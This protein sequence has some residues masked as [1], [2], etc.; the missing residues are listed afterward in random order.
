MAAEPSEITFVVPGQ[1][2]PT[3]QASTALSGTVKAAVRVGARRGAGETVRMSARPG[4][5]VVLLHIANGPTLCLHPENA[6]ELVQA[7]VGGTPPTGRSQAQV[8]GEVVVPAQLGWRGLEAAP[9]TRGKLLDWAGGVVLDGIEVVTGLLKDKL[10]D[11]A[12]AAVT[13]KLDGQVDAGVY[14]LSSKSLTR[15]KGAGEKVAAVP[16]P[17]KPRDPILVLVHGT[18]VET[19]STF[20]KLWAKH[21]AQ[22]DGL[23]GYYGGRVYAL[24]HPTVGVSPFGNALT[25][26]RVLPKGASVHLVTHSRG[27]LVAEAIARICGG[28]GLGADA[29]AL[30][31]GDRYAQ[32]RADLA[33]LAHEIKDR[34]I[35]V[36][37]LLRVACP[38][39]GTLLASRRLDAYLSVLKWTIELAGV[40]VLP[41]L[42]DFLSEVARRRA[43]PTEL[44]G[45]E[46]M[47]PGRPV[48]EWLNARAEPVAGDLR[49]VAGD[50]EG[51]SVLSWL[52]TLLADSFYWTDN[53]LVVQTRSMYGGTPR[54][55]GAASFVL[56]RGGKVTHFDYF[57]N[58]ST[59]DLISRGL[60]QDQP[61]EFLPIG[62]LSWAGEDASGSR[63]ARA[64]RRSREGNVAERP[65]VF[66]L[67]GILGSHLKVDGQRVW[68]SLRFVNSLE[69]LKWDPGTVARVQPDGPIG[70]SYDDLIDHLAN[71]HEVIPFSFDWRR[72]LEDEARRLA[73]A[74][75]SAL[76][77]R[78]ATQQPVRLLAHSMGGLVARS[79][80]LERPETWRRMMSRAGARIL[81]LG[82][83]NGGSFVPM[84]VLSGDDSF[85]NLLSTVGSLFDGR[86]ARQMIAEMPGLLQLQAGLVDGAHGLDKTAGWERLADADLAVVRQ[87]L[88][89]RSWWHKDELQVDSFRWGVPPQGVLD[90][91]VALRRK[92][93]AQRDSL[94]ED[95]AKILLVVG[96]APFTPAE[97]T[98]GEGGAVYLDAPDDGDGRVTFSSACLPGVRTWQVDVVHGDLADAR[99]AFDAYVDL[100]TSGDTRL[101]PVAGRA[102]AARGTGS[103]ARAVA[104]VPNRPARALRGGEPPADQSDVFALVAAAEPRK[105][106]SGSRLRVRV[107]N[108]NLKFVRYPLVVGHYRSL[109]LTGTEYVIDRLLDGAMSE[110]LRAGLY[111]SSLG[112]SQVFTNTR[113]NP[114]DPFVLPR[115]EAV[116]VV[117]LGEEGVLR[118][119]GLTEAVRQGVLAY[120]QRTAE[121][122]GGG[123]TTF[124]LAATLLGSGGSDISAGMSAQAIATGVRQA[125]RRLAEIEWPQVANLQLIELFLDRATEALQALGTLADTEAQDLV[126]EPD[127]KRGLGGLPRPNNVGYR[128]ADYDF[129]SVQQPRPE[130]DPMVEFTL[131][132]RRARSEVRGVSTQSKLVDAL[133]RATATNVSSDPPTRRS[134]FKLLVP[135]E[136]EAFLTGSSSLLM[137]LDRNT[138]A[139]PWEL[140]DTQS[141]EFDG[142]SDSKPWAVRTR[143]LRKLRTD[144][145]RE[146]PQDASREAA[147]LVIGEPQCPPDK[148]PPLPGAAAE[149]RAVAE[150]LGTTPVLNQDALAVVKAVLDQ[151]YKILHVAGHG[152]VLDGVGGIVLSDGT[153]FG[154]TEVKAMRTVPEL[155]FINCCHLGRFDKDPL[156]RVNRIGSSMPKFAAN[157][158]EELINIGVRCVIAAGWAV[159]DEPAKLFASRFYDALSRGRPFVEAVEQA[160]LETWRRH[161]G[162]NTWAAYQCYGDP[163]WTYVLVKAGSASLRRVPDVPSAD[164]MALRLGA[165]VVAHAYEDRTT[166]DVRAQVE[167]LEAAYGGRWG[168]EGAVATAFGAVYAEIGDFARAI[169]WYSRALEAEDGGASLRAMEQL[170]NARARGGAK[171]GDLDKARA[172]IGAGIKL[173][174]RV[175]DIAPTVERESLL[176]S[177]HKRMA[178]LERAKHPDRERA[179]LAQSLAHYRKAEDIARKKNA[180][181]LYYPAMNRMS[182]ALVLGPGQ[183]NPEGFDAGDVSA[184]RQSLQKKNAD[185]PDFWSVVG[186]TELRI[187]EALAHCRLGPALDGIL[188]DL[189]DL[190]PRA[191]STRLWASV[192]D[193]ARFTLVPYCESSAVPAAEKDAAQKLLSRFQSGNV[194]PRPPAADAAGS[195]A[196]PGRA[197]R[198]APA[199]SGRRGKPRSRKK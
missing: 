96:Q 108:G 157:V 102:G 65:A 193:Q 42:V 139:Y 166:D 27:G 9:A 189:E 53:D 150:V 5:D 149:A 43:D 192:A 199:S 75:E 128:G 172:E 133:V 11:L 88:A 48:T 134:L 162:S 7:Q 57:G 29:F 152:D 50:I 17:P 19:S 161:R 36:E 35:R 130:T 195:P 77:A 54:A 98:I 79:V 131:D 44:P 70:M 16:A 32:H 120:A 116:I 103:E 186:V 121:R 67:P 39:R 170:G 160:R 33:E 8:D 55:A 40:P 109:K 85:G 28:Q 173:L 196:P 83:P 182:I 169:D 165:L 159:D 163:D 185:D 132:T 122:A 4:D 175:N 153:I 91:A 26:V 64:A 167:Q 179:A 60:T 101:L 56:D 59:A 94:G 20:G 37:R 183:P 10:T 135:L 194:P 6:R 197:P 68:L 89:E 41:E 127:I 72:P 47:M 171:L 63:A 176:G 114:D 191:M 158:A 82:T 124:E 164:A 49:V 14:R 187:Y 174:E 125:N 74:I 143:L 46:A 137:Q 45:L 105:A 147:V 198:N 76:T 188:A 80:Q 126:L 84:Q 148:Y 184:V 168:N 31:N 111:P 95:A 178:L 112:S 113:R 151:P 15:L 106:T 142:R 110:S 30:F 117:G 99:P 115:P 86:A 22:V 145:Y 71:T 156:T 93:D 90:Q 23:F 190:M 107:V 3:G 24:D 34:E 18:F 25:L 97:V 51:D 177:A 144:R 138:A 123:S 81:M 21:S 52:K 66:V 141:P 13:K 146:Q 62:P 140:L 73:D 119:S 154:S 104:L 12:A 181:N 38:A 92:F 136:I 78:N 100:L 61:A 87:R 69:R 1:A 118:L 2:L 129:V 155:V 180:D 58:E